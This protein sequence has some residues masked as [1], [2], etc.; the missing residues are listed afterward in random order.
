LKSKRGDDVRLVAGK[1]A[2]VAFAVWNGEQR[3]RNG[4]KLVSN[5]Y[6]LVLER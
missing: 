3:D 2:P 5:W 1:P 6:Q 4:R